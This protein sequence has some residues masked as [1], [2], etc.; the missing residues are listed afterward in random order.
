MKILKIVSIKLFLCR[1]SIVGTI[2]DVP[3]SV[4]DHIAGGWL[5]SLKEE[6]DGQ[7]KRQNTGSEAELTTLEY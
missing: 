3:N 7:L 6:R 2:R 4:T 5:Q 1:L